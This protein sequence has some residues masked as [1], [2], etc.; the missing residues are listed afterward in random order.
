MKKSTNEKYSQRG[1]SGVRK[2]VFTGCMAA[3]I[4]ILT[5]IV[6]IPT[7]TKGYVNIGDTGVILASAMLGPL[8]GA[9]ASGIGSALAD[10]ISGYMVYAPVTLII[11]ALMAVFAALIIRKVRGNKSIILAVL[12]CEAIMVLGYFLF[13]I[14]MAG[15]VAAAAA[16]IPMNILQG[17]INGIAGAIIY[18]AA[19]N[20]LPKI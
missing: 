5:M 14:F 18:I 6:K 11:K 2:I 9:L 20:Y 17:V 19:K 1:S 12:F 7:P 4:C 8:Y 3:I 16:G 13:E 15:S 10:I